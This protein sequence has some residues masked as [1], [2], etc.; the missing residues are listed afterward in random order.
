MSKLQI[1][2]MIVF[3][4]SFFTNGAMAQNNPLACQVEEA[5]GL[6]WENGRWV[7]TK[8]VLNKFILVQAGKTLTTE[9]VAKVL[10]NPYPTQITCKYSAPEITCFDNSGRTLYFNLQALKG[11]TSRLF[12]ST[13][14]KSTR[15]S[16]AVEVFS[17][18]PF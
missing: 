2:L 3:S 7:Q 5:A 12:G 14:G 16:V 1:T 9:S 18:T 6:E 8:F 15:D 17:C 10:S 11:G 13:S 4:S